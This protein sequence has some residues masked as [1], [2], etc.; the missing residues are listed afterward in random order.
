MA[1]DFVA[2]QFIDFNLLPIGQQLTR[3][4][5]ITVIEC[6]TNPGEVMAE[7]AKSESDIKQGHVPS[8]GKEPA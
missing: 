5:L 4:W 3:Q 8:H 1:N 7:L 2:G 6:I